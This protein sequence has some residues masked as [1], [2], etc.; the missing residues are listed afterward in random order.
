[1]VRA[2]GDPLDLVPS[3]RATLAEVA[4][5]V[6]LTSIM[7][8]DE[9]SLSLTARSRAV[10]TILALFGAVALV[11]VAVG[12]YGMIGFMV[13][14]RTREI[15]LR[16][17]LGA[18]R[19]SLAALV[20]KQGLAVTLIGIGVGLGASAVATRF[21][22]SLLFDTPSRDSAAMAGM[23]TALFLVSMAASYVPALRAMR[24]DPMVALQAE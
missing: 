12:L 20:L 9:R 8:M 19:A 4:S 10:T 21:L 6:P 11:L 5:D 17:S 14:H 22:E 3:L 13:A 24:V 16:A 15:G 1:M 7:T 23:A 2:S 18:D